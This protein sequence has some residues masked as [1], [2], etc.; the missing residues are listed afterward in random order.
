MRSSRSQ[1][2]ESRTGVEECLQGNLRGYREVE[3]PG[4]TPWTA[5]LGLEGPCM[6]AAGTGRE[7]QG[8]QITEAVMATVPS[9]S[10]IL[11]GVAHFLRPCF[12]LSLSFLLSP[13]HSGFCSSSVTDTP[14]SPASGPLHMLLGHFLQCPCSSFFLPLPVCSEPL[15]P[16]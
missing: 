8:L 15:L 1:S 3:L 9:D 4:A 16:S 10:Q 2:Q 6:A 7:P 13:S 14:S 11:Q 12:C 5:N